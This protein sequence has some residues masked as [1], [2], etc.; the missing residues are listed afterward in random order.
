MHLF[1]RSAVAAGVILTLSCHSAFADIDAENLIALQKEI[2]ALRQENTLLRERARLQKEN[3]VLRNRILP[4]RE[5]TSRRAA[6]SAE[7]AARHVAISSEQAYAAANRPVKAPPVVAAPVYNWTGFYFGGNVGLAAGTAYTDTAYADAALINIFGLGPF[8][9]SNSLKLNG[10][11]G[12][13]QIGYNWQASPNWVLGV[14]ADWQGSNEKNGESVSDTAVLA[15]ATSTFATNYEEKISWFGTLRG[16]TGYAWD[17]LLI[18]GTGGLAYGRVSLSGT[19]TLTV[20]ANPLCGGCVSGVAT[21]AFETSSLKVG[22]AAGA[23]IES[24]ITN[25]WSW[26][27]EYLYMDLGSL[28]VLLP[29]VF[30]GS[31]NFETI[32]A[33]AHFTHNI[34]R[35]GIN[36]KFR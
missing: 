13:A 35:G 15:A 32:A 1:S 34:A 21:G 11:I 10:I 5:P 14:E 22:W 6:E 3:A 30:P 8:L 33:H 2:A 25:N 12:G 27:A 7:A 20:V 36:Y 29:G 17:R 23:G 26:R 4:Q 18:Y 19:T 16:R 24:A 28:D 31:P 9:H